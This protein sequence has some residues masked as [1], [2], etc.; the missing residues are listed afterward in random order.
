MSH[1]ILFCRGFFEGLLPE[2]EQIR[3]FIGK[4]YGINPKNEFSLLKAIGYDCAGAVSFSDYEENPK[5]CKKT[6]EKF[7]K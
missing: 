5:S 6:I 4:K 2:G 7:N 1:L 3:N